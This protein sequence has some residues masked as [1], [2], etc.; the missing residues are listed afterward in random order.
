MGVQFGHIAWKVML[1][2]DGNKVPR[3]V[4]KDVNLSIKAC[5]NPL[6]CTT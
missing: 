2:V 4:A 1:M 6:R 3:N 5:E